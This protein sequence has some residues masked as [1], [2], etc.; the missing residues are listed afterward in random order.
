[1]VGMMLKIIQN[2]LPQNNVFRQSLRPRIWYFVTPAVFCHSLKQK[3]RSLLFPLCVSFHELDSEHQNCILIH[4]GF[5]AKCMNT[6][7]IF[8]HALRVF[9]DVENITRVLVTL[10]L[11][12]LGWWSEWCV[13]EDGLDG[14]ER[15]HLGGW[16]VAGVLYGCRIVM[17]LRRVGVE[18]ELCG[19]G[20]IWW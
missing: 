18:G 2:R 6:P 15:L 3:E 20:R 1:M 7:L 14:G 10:H 16:M 4:N 8:I 9:F 13:V 17:W 12:A 19:W 11:G 5:F